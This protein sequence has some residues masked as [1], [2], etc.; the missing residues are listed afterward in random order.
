MNVFCFLGLRTELFPGVSGKEQVV[1]NDILWLI[2]M[3]SSIIS[4]NV[5]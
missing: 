1:E 4:F 2:Y 5:I 3:T